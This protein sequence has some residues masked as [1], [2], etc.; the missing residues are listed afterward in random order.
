M[1]DKNLDAASETFQR[2]LQLTPDDADL[3]DMMAYYLLCTG[4]ASE[5]IERSLK[6]IRASPLFLPA[7]LRETMGMAFM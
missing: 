5:A 4:Q 2:A 7:S 1:L 3:N 6:T